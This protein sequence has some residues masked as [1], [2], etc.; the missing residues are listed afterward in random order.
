MQKM[1]K[2]TYFQLGSTPPG[3]TTDRFPPPPRSAKMEN[4]NGKNRASFRWM[5]SCAIVGLLAASVSPC[6]AQE[7]QSASQEMQRLKEMER[8]LAARPALE[9]QWRWVFIYHSPGAHGG[10]GI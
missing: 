4:I 9:A 8:V 3:S 2:V 7:N 6:F 5:P 1:E 10:G